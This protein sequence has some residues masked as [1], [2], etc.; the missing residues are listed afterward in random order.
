[1][2]QTDSVVFLTR[3]ETNTL[4]SISIAWTNGVTVKCDVQPMSREQA[5]KSYGLEANSDLK[6]V[7]D[8]TNAAWVL[9]DQVTYDSVNWWVRLVDK[10]NKCN[11]SNHTFVILERVV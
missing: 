2:W 10:F 7:F 1:M 6:Q 8:H 5:R 11:K 3:T 4:G 9:G